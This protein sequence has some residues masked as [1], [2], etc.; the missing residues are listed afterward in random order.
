MATE[1]TVKRSGK[2]TQITE[3]PNVVETTQIVKEA[4]KQTGEKAKS[5]KVLEQVEQQVKEV[6]EVKEV[7]KQRGEKKEKIEKVESEKIQT[8]ASVKSEE[9]ISEQVDVSMRFD[10]QHDALLTSLTE[11]KNK[12]REFSFS[13]KKL[14]IAYKHDVK[15][16][17]KQ[18]K[19]RK[20][21]SKAT[22][23]IKKSQVPER[24]AKFLH[25]E[26]GTELSGPEITKMVWAELKARNLQYDGDKRIFRTDKE[27]SKVFNVPDSVNQSTNHKDKGGFNFCNIQKYISYALGN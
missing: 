3:E 5:A 25:I 27:V 2:K 11:L 20:L 22:G 26:E 14:E 8:D 1:K 18:K 4:G 7:K 10:K 9:E 23:F 15:K 12:V 19:K 21:T 13:M 6:K 17:S 24:L 16:A